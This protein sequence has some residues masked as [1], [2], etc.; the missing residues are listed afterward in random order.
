MTRLTEAQ[1]PDG[2]LLRVTPRRSIAWAP[3]LWLAAVLLVGG[4][5]V[6]YDPPEPSD[7]VAVDSSGRQPV[8]SQDPDA[9][10]RRRHQD[11]RGRLHRYG[12]GL[13]KGL[14]IAAR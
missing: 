2:R 4:C 8:A 10:R 3:A 12:P 13:R 9:E 14:P 7:A 5:I 11:R 6:H 1:P